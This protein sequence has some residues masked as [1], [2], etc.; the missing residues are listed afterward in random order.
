MM[1]IDQDLLHR[2]EKGLN[3]QNLHDSAIAAS[4]IGYGEISAI[5]QIQGYNDIVLKRMPLFSDLSSAKH[6][7]DQYY[8]YCDLLTDAGLN[9][10]QHDTCIIQVPDRPVVLYI[11]QEILDVNRF[12][13]R[14]IHHQGRKGTRRLIET[15]AAEISKIWDFNRTRQP[16]LEVAIDGQLS[17]WV[18]LEKESRWQMYYVDTSTPLYRKNGIEQQNPELLL[19]STPAF[20]RWIIRLMFLEDVMTRYYH[21]RLVYTD[22]A[23]N[24]YKEQRPDLV[25]PAVD[26]INQ[27][28][29]NDPKPLTVKEVKRYYRE[30]KWIW[31]LFLTFRKIDRWLTT[32]LLGKR[33]EFILPG[34]IKR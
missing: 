18:C 1:K 9:L 23:A 20:L 33:Y 24:L 30:D 17:N 3:P 6:Y 7:A 25:P 11:A 22:L 19:K 10:P 5:F 15:I 8:E 29:T 31:I 28:L 26:M 21:P 14:L 2:F 32:R 16:L 34:R 27:F 13:H 4:I 12:C